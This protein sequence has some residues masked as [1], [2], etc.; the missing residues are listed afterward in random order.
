MT[1]FKPTVPVARF[2]GSAFKR[3]IHIY[4]HVQSLSL[5]SPSSTSLLFLKQIAAKP[6]CTTTR[7][8]L[9]VVNMGLIYNV[10]GLLR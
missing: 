4:F 5:L 8:A 2:T 3:D 1:P 10:P 9:F 7:T 6:A